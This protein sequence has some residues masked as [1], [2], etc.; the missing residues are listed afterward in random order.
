MI[1]VNPPVQA[2]QGSPNFKTLE[3]AH[4]MG[5]HRELVDKASDK[6]VT[7]NVRTHDFGLG[8]FQS[9]VSVDMVNGASFFLEMDY[10]YLGGKLKSKKKYSSMFEIQDK[11]LSSE[12]KKKRDRSLRREKK[13]KTNPEYPIISG[14]SL[15]DSGIQTKWKIARSEAK[16]SLELGKKLGMKIQGSEKEVE[17][18]KENWTVDEVR[19]LWHHD[20]FEFRAVDSC[21]R[22]GGV[23]TIWDRNCFSEVS[24]NSNPS[25]LQQFELKQVVE[26]KAVEDIDVRVNDRLL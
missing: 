7:E 26:L 15:S 16:K 24:V 13:L 23:I 25:G 9:G 22:S 12:E 21:G 5:L 18:K 4:I 3:D 20:E 1:V 10:N 8:K 6:I 11:V 14:R 19:K 17:T 2:A